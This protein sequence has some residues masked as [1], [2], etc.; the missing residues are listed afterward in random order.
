MGKAGRG[1]SKS[2][3]TLPSS[4]TT[5]RA[6]TVSVS[7]AIQAPL[8][9]RSWEAWVQHDLYPF[10]KLG[11]VALGPKL[12]IAKVCTHWAFEVDEPCSW[13]PSP[14]QPSLFRTGQTEPQPTSQSRGPTHRIDQSAPLV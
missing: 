2:R 7:R 14:S 9:G 13:A 5:S 1:A 8:P 12:D 3:V 6:L 4:P 11:S 10:Y